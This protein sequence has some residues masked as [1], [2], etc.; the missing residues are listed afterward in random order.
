MPVTKW[1][2][3]GV[4]S[5]DPLGMSSESP[6]KE[7]RARERHNTWCLKIAPFERDV[8]KSQIGPTGLMHENTRG[9]RDGRMSSRFCQIR[10]LDAYLGSGCSRF[11]K[12]YARTALI[13]AFSASSWGSI[14][15]R[16]SAAV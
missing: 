2:V 4:T 14:L 11:A 7:T 6:R 1:W 16:V 9:C 13:T 8:V 12:A 5:I 15:S 3:S 10:G